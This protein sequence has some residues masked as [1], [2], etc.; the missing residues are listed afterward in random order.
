MTFLR[1]KENHSLR[2]GNFIRWKIKKK[3]VKEKYVNCIKRTT[4]KELERGSGVR[5]APLL[6]KIQILFPVPSQTA[7]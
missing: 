4:T 5:S 2:N 7:V 1:D 3:V 6:Q